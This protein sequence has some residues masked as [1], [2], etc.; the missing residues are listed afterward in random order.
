MKRRRGRMGQAL[1]E[2]AFL[3]IL[4]ATVLVA[5]VALAGNQVKSTVTKLE[6]CISQMSNQNGE[7]DFKK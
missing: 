1:I 2:Y 4:V 3:M 7:C 6:T 5:V